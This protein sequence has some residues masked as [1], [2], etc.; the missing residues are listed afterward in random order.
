VSGGV[1]LLSRTTDTA[2]TYGHIRGG[3]FASHPLLA[4]T[5]R[6]RF[7]APRWEMRAEGAPGR[8]LATAIG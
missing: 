6:A 2:V 7:C 4:V 3:C 1:L 5:L 8:Q